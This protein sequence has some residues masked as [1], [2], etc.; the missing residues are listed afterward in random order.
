MEFLKQEDQRFL[1]NKGKLYGYYHCCHKFGH[2]VVDCR[3]RGKDQS[4]RRN[5]DTNTEDDKGQ[6]RRIPHGKT[7]RKN[8]YYKNSKEKQISNISEVS[9]DD[10]EHNS[11][12][13][14]KD[15][16][17]EEKQD[18]NVKEYTYKDEGDEEGYSDAVWD[19]FLNISH[20]LKRTLK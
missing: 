7:W 3:T 4:L 19:S 6:V 12:I 20:E 18:G 14:K 11:A 10:D 1:K 15:I 2:K 5:Q 8:L 9:K 13:D 17:Y 16:H